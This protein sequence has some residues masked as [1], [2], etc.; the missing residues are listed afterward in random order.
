[1]SE[2][3]LTFIGE[4]I[5]LPDGVDKRDLEWCAA[6]AGWTPCSMERRAINVAMGIAIRLLNE[7]AEERGPLV[8]SRRP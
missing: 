7:K 5:S 8:A 1:M 3:D 2:L 6:V 4:V